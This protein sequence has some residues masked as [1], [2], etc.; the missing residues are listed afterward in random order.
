[1]PCMFESSSALRLRANELTALEMVM[2]S[3]AVREGIRRERQR[4]WLVWITQTQWALPAACRGQSRGYSTAAIAREE[5]R[6]AFAI[7]EHLCPRG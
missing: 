3:R 7:R 4:K 5:H 1:M 6:R 2:R